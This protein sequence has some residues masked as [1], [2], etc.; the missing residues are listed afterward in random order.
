MP[1]S[2]QKPTKKKRSPWF[3]VL[4]V[5]IPIA[6]FLSGLAINKFANDLKQQQ[7]EDAKDAK[8]EAFV[9]DVKN[10]LDKEVPEGKWEISEYCAET[11]MKGDLLGYSCSY[12]VQSKQKIN[13]NTKLIEVFNN[14]L[15]T[16]FKH[17]YNDSSKYSVYYGKIEP[18][19]D[20]SL[21]I[22][23]DHTRT[24]VGCGTSPETPRYE[25]VND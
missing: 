23:D 12:D 18:S 22:Y 19:I 6:L 25:I 7:A 14:H 16:P 24:S 11:R 21:I 9:Q 20:C 15:T 8:I 2:K 13:A 3:W 5:T 1:I 4:I 10:K 17:H